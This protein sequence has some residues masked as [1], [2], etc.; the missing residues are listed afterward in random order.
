MP[1]LEF[2]KNK[3][4]VCTWII[5]VVLLLVSTGG[6]LALRHLYRISPADPTGGRA[7][8]WAAA[9]ETLR[10]Y[11]AQ[12]ATLR[13]EVINRRK[14]Y[15]HGGSSREEVKDAEES[16]IAVLS[17]IQEAR[18]DLLAIDLAAAEAESRSV[19]TQTAV[20]TDDQEPAR[21]PTRKDYRREPWSLKEAPAIDQYFYQSFG[22]RMPISAFGQT[23]THS[24]MGFDHHRAMDVAVSPDSREGKALIGYLRNSG[25][26]FIAF[27]SAVANSSTGAHIH[28]GPPS[29][30]I[31]AAAES[32]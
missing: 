28:V 18:R 22:Y 11:E 17:R 4:P 20:L 5:T 32:R 3:M 10:A 25:I 21:R 23:P 7:Q 8:T 1:L 29:Y 6:L 13:V 2:S 19:E 30:R 27:R 9:H 14:R 12:Q 26:P 15:E 24:R 31:A 16:L